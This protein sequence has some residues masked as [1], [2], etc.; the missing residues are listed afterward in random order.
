MCWVCYYTPHRDEIAWRIIWAEPLAF[1]AAMI[2]PEL[3]GRI[4]AVRNQARKMP[5][6]ALQSPPAGCLE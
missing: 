3:K 5:N 6:R 1:V 2:G 4:L